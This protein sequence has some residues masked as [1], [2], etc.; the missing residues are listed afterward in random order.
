MHMVA[1][2]HSQVFVI[3]RIDKLYTLH[4]VCIIRPIPSIM[5]IQISP[6]Y[7]NRLLPRFPV[8]SY[9]NST[10]MQGN[11]VLSIFSRLRG[12]KDGEKVRKY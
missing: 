8:L 11:N 6:K 1:F 10:H 12:K 5:C 3:S 9:R 4:A 7:Y 2:V